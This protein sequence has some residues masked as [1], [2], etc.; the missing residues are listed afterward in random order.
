MACMD[1]KNAKKNIY[2]DNG[3][4]ENVQNMKYQVHYGS[5][6]KLYKNYQQEKTLAKVKTQRCIFQG[7]ALP[8]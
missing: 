2:M 7:D 8:L 1:Y 4:S 6:A 3:L 5:N